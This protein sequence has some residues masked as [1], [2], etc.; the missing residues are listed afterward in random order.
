MAMHRDADRAAVEAASLRAIEEAS[1][2]EFI[3]GEAENYRE[4]TPGDGGDQELYDGDGTPRGYFFRSVSDRVIERLLRIADRI[5]AI[6]R[7]KEIR[8]GTG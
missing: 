7:G 4:C 1:D 5:D 8:D 6:D 3:R 2:A